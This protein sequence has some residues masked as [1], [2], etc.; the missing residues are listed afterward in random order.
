LIF[1]NE[2]NESAV[3]KARMTFDSPLIDWEVNTQSIPVADNQGKE[4]MV[5]FRGLDIDNLETFY[6]D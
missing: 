1:E 6:T 5:N 4:V 3:V 2:K